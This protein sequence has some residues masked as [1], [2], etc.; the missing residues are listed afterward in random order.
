MKKFYNRGARALS[1]YWKDVLTGVPQG[2]VL[3][4]LLFLLY[5]NDFPDVIKSMLKLFGDDAKI[6]QTTD[7]C[8]ILQDD[9]SEGGSWADKWELKF[10]VDKC[11]VIIMEEP[12]TITVIK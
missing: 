5:V 12:M 2:S 6:Y 10:H 9:L 8:D 3:G 7:K 1:I 11:G 4:P